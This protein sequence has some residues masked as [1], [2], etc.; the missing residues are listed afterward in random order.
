M[1]IEHSWW[2][3]LSE[4]QKTSY[5]PNYSTFS[6][7]VV[8]GENSPSNMKNQHLNYGQPA[9]ALV[10]TPWNTLRGILTLFCF[11]TKVNLSI[12]KNGHSGK[13]V[14]RTYS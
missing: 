12:D 7:M 1:I 3:I 6:S 9:E 14:M 10:K 2:L 11:H 5:C 4:V 8:V 13:A